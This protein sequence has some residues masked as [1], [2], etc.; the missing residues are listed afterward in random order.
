MSV[1]MGMSVG[2]SMSVSV[3]AS[4]SVSGSAVERLVTLVR[5]PCIWFTC[6][7]RKPQGNGPK[8]GG[9]NGCGGV[10]SKTPHTRPQDPR[11]AK[12]MTQFNLSSI[13][14]NPERRQLIWD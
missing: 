12:D 10:A 9:G 5:S 6:K 14:H 11:N 4:A 13:Q 8:V 2:V 7:C 3:N 1:S